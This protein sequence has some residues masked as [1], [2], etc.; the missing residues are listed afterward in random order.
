M[1]QS[2]NNINEQN[3]STIPTPALFTSGTHGQTAG[4]G[5]SGGAA[6]GGE[7]NGATVETNDGALRDQN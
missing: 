7:D 2:E 1:M 4:G 5:G 3:S 6:A